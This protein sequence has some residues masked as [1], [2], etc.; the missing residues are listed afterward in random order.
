MKRVSCAFSRSQFEL[1]RQRSETYLMRLY[2]ICF[3]TLGGVMISGCVAP[4]TMAEQSPDLN[5]AHQSKIVIAV[6]DERVSPRGDAPKTYIGLAQDAFGKA[7][8]LRTYPWIVSDEEKRQQALS[9]VL[10]E[11]IVFG[12][13]DEGWNAVLARFSDVPSEPKAENLVRLH[14]AENI[15]VLTLKNWNVNLNLN[16]ITPLVLDWD[17]VVTVIDKSGKKLVEFM[18]SGTDTVD[19]VA[20]LSIADHIR[21]AYRE[22]L[23]RILEAEK[24]RVALGADRNEPQ[25]A[26][27]EIEADGSSFLVDQL[28]ML[29]LLLDNGTITEKEF[30]DLVRRAVDTA[31]NTK[32]D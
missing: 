6:I 23:T 27:A 18:D 13:N 15:L 9:G 11:R 10:A 12:L 8:T 22:R 31:G 7:T 17:I 24:I 29:Q 5:Y 14:N 3:S 28:K 4:M 30:A 26:D 32:V 1:T 21:L 2:Q 25:V 16:W 20:G 19:E